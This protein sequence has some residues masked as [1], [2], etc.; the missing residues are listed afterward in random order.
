MGETIVIDDRVGQND[1]LSSFVEWFCDVSEALLACGVPD[2]E[3]D[4]MIVKL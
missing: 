2:V 4:L 1:T 3:S